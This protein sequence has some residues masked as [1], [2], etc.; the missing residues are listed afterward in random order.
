MHNEV[1]KAFSKANIVEFPEAGHASYAEF[2]ELLIKRLK[3]S[4]KEFDDKSVN[5][6]Q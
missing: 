2:P 5:L 6:K 3:N 4:R 1:V